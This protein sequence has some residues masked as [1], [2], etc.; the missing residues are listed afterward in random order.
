MAKN[1][2]PEKVSFTFK[3]TN[4]T[5]F[6]L[7]GFWHSFDLISAFEGWQD[8]SLLPFLESESKDKYYERLKDKEI[9]AVLLPM[10]RDYGK[11][12]RHLFTEEFLPEFVVTQLRTISEMEQFAATNTFADETDCVLH[13][14]NWCELEMIWCPPGDFMMGSPEKEYGHC[15]SENY[16]QVTI[17]HGFWLGKYPVTQEQYKVITGKIPFGECGSRCVLTM[18]TRDEAKDFCSRL[19]AAFKN[20]LPAGYQ[21][22][23]PSEAQWEY[24][25]RAG[26]T[27]AFSNG[28]DMTEE[29]S[30]EDYLDDIA[31]CPEIDDFDDFCGLLTYIPRPVGQYAPNPWGFYDMH[32][33][34]EEWCSDVYQ[35]E[36]TLCE[37]CAAKGGSCIAIA[38]GMP[39]S[40]RSAACAHYVRDYYE[41]DTGFRLALKKMEE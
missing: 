27:T 35:E 17:G 14:P 34:V 4:K 6:S 29:D 32:G 3:R 33:N 24:A 18:I 38:C 12:A 10:A 13:L 9:E 5:V 2:I 15:E 1:D 25:C 16:H 22:D 26:T 20:V 23:L 31:W 30:P 21:F 40:C 11:F 8:G 19:N 28:K 39:E 7:D 36:D 41:S 37:R